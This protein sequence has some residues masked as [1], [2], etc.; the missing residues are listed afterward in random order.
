MTSGTSSAWRSFDAFE[1]TT[2]PA[3]QKAGSTA[4][5]TPEGSAENTSSTS[6]DTAPGAVSRTVTSATPSGIG[7][8]TRHFAASR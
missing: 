4:A 5:A 8:S 6:S 3:S 1:Q 7:L 2:W